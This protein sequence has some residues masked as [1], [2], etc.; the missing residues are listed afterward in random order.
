[1]ELRYALDDLVTA[2]RS[3]AGTTHFSSLDCNLTVPGTHPEGTGAFSP[4]FEASKS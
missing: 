2:V 3:P 1:M 4:R